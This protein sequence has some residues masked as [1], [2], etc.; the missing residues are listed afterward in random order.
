MSSTLQRALR[1]DDGLE[2]SRLEARAPARGPIGALAPVMIVVLVAYLIIGL[3]MAS[4]TI[5]GVD[6]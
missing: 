3:A 4:A 1:A 6:R 5:K 2:N